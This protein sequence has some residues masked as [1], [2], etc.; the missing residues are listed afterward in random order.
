MRE[1]YEVL[2]IEYSFKFFKVPIIV[3]EGKF[4]FKLFELSLVKF[5][6]FLQLQF[7][8]LRNKII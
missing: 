2:F 6:K 1:S 7:F 4:E 8:I 5:M 3:I